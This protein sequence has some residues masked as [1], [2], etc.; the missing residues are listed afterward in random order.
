MSVLKTNLKHQV[1]QTPLPKWKPLIPLFEAVMNSIQSVRENRHL[2]VPGHVRITVE[3]DSDLLGEELS[4][5]GGFI[6]EDNGVGLTDEN[7][8]SFNTA[9]SDHKEKEGGKGLGRFTWL[10]AFVAA[11]IETVFR[12]AGEAAHRRKF[13]F[14]ENYDPD[15][16]LPSQTDIAVTGMRV[17]LIGLREP[18][19]SKFPRSADQIVQ[20]LVEHF[21][22]ILLEPNCPSIDLVDGSLRHSVNEAFEKDFKA[23]AKVHSFAIRGTP[24]T[25]HGFRLTTPRV[26]NH[27]LVYAANQRG[28]VSDFLNKF[29]PNLSTRLP[30]PDGTTFIYFGI[31]QSPYLTQHVNPARTDFD[32]GS[33]EDAEAEQADL[34][35]SEIRLSEIRE[36]ALGL[37]QVDLSEV[38][39]EL[40]QT[41][42][43][44]IRSYVQTEAPQYKVLLKYRDEFIN[45]ISPSA[46]KTDIE[47]ALHRELY[48]REVEMKRQGSRIIKE[49]E[50]ISDY[51]DYHK[52][53]SAFMDKYN[54]LGT[55]AL[56]QYVAHRKILLEF[57]KDAISRSPETN[58]YPL[59]EV[60]H[61]LVFPMRF[62][63]EDI[64]SHEQ[65]LWMLDERLTFH[66]FVASDKRL[67]GISHRLDSDSAMRPDLFIFD[68]K[69]IFSDTKPDEHPV[70]SI[71][72]VEF[73]KP[74]RD[75]YSASDNPVMQSFKLVEQIRAGKFMRNGR[76]VSVA[77]DHIPAT[78]YAVCDLTDTLRSALRDMDADATPD[79]QGYYGFHRGYRVFYEVLDYNKLLRDAEKRNRIFFDKLNIIG[80][81]AQQ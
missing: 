24:F 7:F 63:D 27:K 51:E 34:F 61:Q 17:R 43:D 47:V 9:F 15:R 73:K 5:I 45:K 26:S 80:G 1:K 13:I 74:G 75:N 65:N 3:R 54:E 32:I 36:K 41:K 59:E 52:K 55:A 68:E 42:E 37:I 46:T 39:T 30:D 69:I 4:P 25:L 21:L 66:S 48:E 71:T 35:D 49:A 67:D 77:N 64:P 60:V 76:P 10:K 28:V 11:E 62:T 23:T 19:K 56:A 40:N 78:V 6:I 18:Y 22:L 57:L 12:P 81:F 2:T 44:R 16:G 72:I 33:N 58:K 20:R 38:L 50:K 8:D 14:D 79:N 31:V 53:L 70:N 29:I